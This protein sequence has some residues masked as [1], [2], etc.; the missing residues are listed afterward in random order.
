MAAPNLR[1][2]VPPLSEFV[3][4]L[5]QS[6]VSKQAKY[7]VELGI[8][9]FLI[10]KIPAERLNLLNLYVEQ[11]QFPE[12]VLAT[13]P[14]RATGTVI[15]LPYDKMYG[16]VA[17]TFTCDRDMKIKSFF[18]SWAGGI[19]NVR[20]GVFNYYDDYIIPELNI[21]QY[22]ENLDTIYCVTLYNVYPKV[23]NDML[24]AAASHEYNRFQVVF[25]YEHWKSWS[26]T[27]PAQVLKVGGSK[28]TAKR[29]MESIMS[30]NIPNFDDLPGLDMLKMGGISSGLDLINKMKNPKLMMDSLKRSGKSMLFE[31]L[32]PMKSQV[33]DLLPGSVK[34]I[35]GSAMG[36]V[37]RMFGL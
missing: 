30:G 22:N 12:F 33:L 14:S 17:M 31:Q 11:A 1:K 9:L 36:Q 25:Q 19:V 26:I 24:V 10:G 28:Y 3:S 15:E 23:V 7:Y 6:S 4:T 5:K 35:G 16:S 13:M 8:P 2:T 20:G 37:G 18:D 32:K 29:L 21:Y 34:Q 27:A